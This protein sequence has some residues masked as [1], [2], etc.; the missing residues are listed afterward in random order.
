ME[1]F[2]KQG[3]DYN[4]KREPHFWAEP[5]GSDGGGAEWGPREEGVAQDLKN[6]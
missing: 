1:A 4:D 6:K 2:S 3:P 5:A